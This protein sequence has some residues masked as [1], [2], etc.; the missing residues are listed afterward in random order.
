[1]KTKKPKPTISAEVQT[2]LRETNG[3]QKTQLRIVKWIV[4]GLKTGAKLEKR[5]FFKKKD[6]T[7]SDLGS[8]KGL[9]KEEIEFVI[10][11]WSEISMFFN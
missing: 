4:D 1:M 6:G 10:A 8:A 5:S 11:N 3:K 7:F 9:T 2:V